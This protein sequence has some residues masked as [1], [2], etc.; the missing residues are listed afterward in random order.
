MSKF[1]RIALVS[2]VSLGLGFGV[3]ACAPS[4]TVDFLY[5]TGSK[6]NPGQISVFK[7][8]GQAGALHQIPD[9]PYGSGGRNP[10]YDVASAN[11][12]N[13]YVINHDDNTMVEFAIGTDGKLYPQQT[14]NLPGSYPVQLAINQAG[15]Y[16]YIVET[17]QPNFSTSIPGPGG[18]VVFPLNANGLVPTSGGS[19]ETVP[20]GASAFFPLGNNPVA[21]NV[22]GNGSF[23]Y[24]VNETD[25]NI[26]AF[27]V[28]S[29]GGLSSIGLFSVG[30]TPN[31][32]ASDPTGK[33]L[34][35]TDGASN[36]MYGFQVQ[37]GGS[38]VMMP[39]PFKTDNL[40]DAVAVDPRG[41]YVYV[42]NYNGNDVNAYTIDQSTGNATPISGST[43]YA[44]GTGP[45][46][47]LIEP[48]EGRYIYTANFLGDTVSG[49]AMN[50][51]TGGLSAVQNTPF[52][53]AQQPTC[54]AAITHGHHTI[55]SP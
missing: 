22:S 11:G 49:L 7:V 55:A 41:I 2:M 44:V 50:V 37:S 26:A 25:H 54:S 40:P 31:A 48:S 43:T 33:F 15:T 47:I 24:A 19:C 36:Q 17:Y 21:V 42:A 20:N 9:S 12:K 18:L 13:L 4:N 6:Q 34:Y 35:V 14:C 28:G 8:D 45:I 10:V 46:C 30:T 39:A 52:G 16:L 1:G 27:Q 23:V 38:L 3:T 32:I 51:A 29:D 53:A 5:V